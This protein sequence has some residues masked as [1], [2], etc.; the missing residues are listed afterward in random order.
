MTTPLPSIPPLIP[1]P[2]QSH[3]QSKSSS[4][5]Q[6]PWT[7]DSTSSEIMTLTQPDESD[8]DRFATLFSPATPPATPTLIFRE[9]PPTTTVPSRPAHQRHRTQSSADSEFGAF[10]SVPPSQDP[11]S[12]DFDF[13]STSPA[14]NVSQSTSF[15]TSQASTPSF[16]SV[17]SKPG[18]SGN[19]SLDYFDQFTSSA[20]TAAE[21]NRRGVLDELLEHQDDPLY[22]LNTPTKV[23]TP[24]SMTPSPPPSLPAA[25]HDEI[26]D[27]LSSE[28]GRTKKVI[29]S[30]SKG[31]LR[32]KPTSSS[33]ARSRTALPPRLS[34]SASPPSISTPSGS[35]TSLPLSPSP[36]PS[37]PP[38]HGTLSRLSSS[39]VSALLPSA[40]P[41]ANVPTTSTTLPASF[42][43][44]SSVSS[45]AS[46]GTSTSGNVSI[47]HGTPFGSAPFIPPSGAPGFAGDRT[48][49]RGFS[50]ALVHDQELGE[51]DTT[52]LGR[53]AEMK[54]KH[55]SAQ[56]KGVSLLG[57]REGTVG[58]LNEEIA[59]LLRPHLP[60]LTRLPRNWTLLYSLD[61]HGISLNTL[62]SRCEP[63][64]PSR[65]NPNP[66]KG[67]LVAIQDAHDTVFGAWLGEGVRL[68]KGGYYGSG[69]SFLWRYHPPESK[70]ARGTL[71]VYKWTGRND[72]V[73]LCEPAFISFGGGDGHYGL[74]LDASL[75]DGSSAPCPTF[76][77]PVLC[78]Q[79]TRP[80]ATGEANGLPQAKPDVSFE[81]VG[82]EVWGVVPG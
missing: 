20:K 6:P 53:D 3:Q 62:Y 58:V 13:A 33:P 15:S 26:A 44:T 67:G 61:Q 60:A 79:T 37:S 78:A 74:Y 66:P 76:G 8:I 35:T 38:A 21:R 71:D 42:T 59:D 81:C 30:Q 12:F 72:Y 1:L 24:S 41:R 65:S 36:P 57:R 46:Y 19:I 11:L 16:T 29:R 5:S 68:E 23:Q 22:F 2:S 64:I 9:Q 40:R 27:A 50:E 73:A 49:D 82:L 17:S 34:Q 7:Q 63:R 70:E 54:A 77:N 43:A 45:T 80:R 28:F 55:K 14:E 51:V 18:K 47:T 32:S 56:G 69:E 75:L 39:W 4:S 10:V 25:K 52:G 48:W 31:S